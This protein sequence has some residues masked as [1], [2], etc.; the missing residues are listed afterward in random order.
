[1]NIKENLITDWQNLMS[2]FKGIGSAVPSWNVEVK[3]NKH[4]V[5][6]KHWDIICHFIN[7]EYVEAVLSYKGE[8]YLTVRHFKKFSATVTTILEYINLNS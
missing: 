3:K 7:N 4:I 5:I 1:M 2:G 8:T 6:N